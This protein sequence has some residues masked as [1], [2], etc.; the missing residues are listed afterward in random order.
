MLRADH[1]VDGGGA[2]GV[3][4]TGALGAVVGAVGGVVG[5]AVPTRYL[6]GYMR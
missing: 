6:F 4:A 1:G 5:A 2:I 3:V